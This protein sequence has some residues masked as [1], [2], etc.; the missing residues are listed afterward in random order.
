MSFAV[1]R[2]V[3]PAAGALLLSSACDRTASRAHEDA[4]ASAASAASTVRVVDDAGDTTTLTR[5][6]SRI[7]SLNPATTEFLVTMGATAR[8]V[9]RTTW[10]TYP[11]AAASIPDVGP[12]IRPNVEAVLA[13]RPDLVLLYA[14]DDNRAAAARLRAAGVPVLALRV[15]R[16]EQFAATATVLGRV[17]GDSV[18]AALVRDSVLASI[19][20]AAAL[21][22]SAVAAPGASTGA[23]PGASTGADTRETSRVTVAWRLWE[24]PLIVLGAGSF[25]SQLIDSVGAR[26]A[27][28]DLP[29]P[30][31]QVGFES[32]VARDPWV[33]V[34]G[35]RARDRVLADPRYRALAAVRAG[36]VIVADTALT[37][38]PGVRMGEAAQWLVRTL[39]ALET[40]RGTPAGT[41]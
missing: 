23:S 17:L 5:P 15:D 31:P 24:Q 9:G 2:V 13:T 14:T 6:A 36:R 40:A 27:F 32:L 39:R 30:S 7:V 26:N 1:R 35:P 33:L 19:A 22:R 11:A 10:D 28:G 20:R 37:G 21:A 8:V 4:P 29:A 12:G 38:R 18:G 25:L 41:P 34:V 3:V 16:I